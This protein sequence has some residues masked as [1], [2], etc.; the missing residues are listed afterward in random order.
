MRLRIGT[1]VNYATLATMAC[2]SIRLCV[3][4]PPPPSD[5]LLLAATAALRQGDAARAG[6]LLAQA[7]EGYGHGATAEQRQLLDL[8]GQRV[9]VALVPGLRSAARAE[10]E[11]PSEQELAERA[12]AKLRGDARL[13]SSVSAFSLKTDAERFS[14]ALGLLD[15]ARTEYRAAGRAIE[16]EREAM[17]GNLYSSICAEKERSE[18]VAKVLRIQKIAELAKGKRQRQELG[19][20]ADDWTQTIE[21]ALRARDDDEV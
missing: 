1:V 5:A 4:P 19:L 14:K 7:R 20:E 11:P 9:D 21:D 13:M 2:T 17:V 6:Q 10:E 15:E 8:V 3:P 16:R 12:A 18:R